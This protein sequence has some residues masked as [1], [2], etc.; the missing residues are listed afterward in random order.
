M[1]DNTTE[2]S[3]EQNTDAGYTDPHPA[4]PDLRAAA[5]PDADDAANQPEVTL[6]LDVLEREKAP[7][8]FYFRHLGA[9]Y[10]LVDPQ[11]VDWQDLILAIGDTY[12]FFRTIVP[13]DDRESFFAAKLPS[14]KMRALMDSYVQHYG[15][16]N[17][18]APSA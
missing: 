17:P 14:W 6:D 12:T 10:L 4:P 9:R 3:T 7:K 16:P 18:K 15:L 8:P 11:E 5:G 2:Q 1:T 13:A